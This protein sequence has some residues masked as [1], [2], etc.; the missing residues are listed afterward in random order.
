MLEKSYGPMLR[1]GPFGEV[2]GVSSEWPFGRGATSR[3]VL[4]FPTPGAVVISGGWKSVG[5]KCM[6][7][8]DNHPGSKRLNVNEQL[9]Y[10]DANMFWGS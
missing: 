2:Y 10:L 5:E 3:S 1:H 7:V 8:M 9:G 4:S 6:E